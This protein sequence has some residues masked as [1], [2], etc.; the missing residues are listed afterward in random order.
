[1]SN[2]NKTIISQQWSWT[3]VNVTAINE[4]ELKRLKKQA[5]LLHQ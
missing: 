5:K 1:M 4:W 3:N 2:C